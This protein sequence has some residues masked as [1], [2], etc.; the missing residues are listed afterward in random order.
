MRCFLWYGFWRP[1]GAPYG[2]HRTIK[3]A[4]KVLP[5][6]RREENVKSSFAIALL[7]A[8]CLAAVPRLH[9][10]TPANGT[11]SGQTNPSANSQSPANTKPQT[12]PRP[13]IDSFPTDTSSVPLLPSNST[14]ASPDRTF[15]G[16]GDESSSP[17]IPLPSVDTDPARSPDDPAGT[18]DSGEDSSSSSSLVGLDRLPKPDDE[19]PGKKRRL[20]VDGPVHPE[21]AKED[22]NVGSYYLEIKNWKAAMSRFQ[23]AMV[24]DPENPEVYWGLAET[25]RHLGNFAEARTHYRQVLDYDPDGPHGKQARKALK[26]PELANAQKPSSAPSTTTPPQ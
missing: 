22:L 19:E 11:G 4:T 8:C 24:L 12:P 18:S 9:A 3:G 17:R 15:G 5:I 10:Q 21:T 25:E 13:D 1:Q 2:P 7:L 23:S 16:Q 14:P 6:T 26:D 20:T